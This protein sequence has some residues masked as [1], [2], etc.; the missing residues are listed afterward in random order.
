MNGMKDEQDLSLQR[1]FVLLRR[2]ESYYDI[3]REALKF[4]S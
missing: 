2:F 1:R 3:S 4:P